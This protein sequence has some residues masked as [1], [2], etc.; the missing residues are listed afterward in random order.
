MIRY[1]LGE[2]TEEDQLRLEEQFLANEE[3]YQ[4]LLALEDELRYEYAQ[5][6]LPARQREQFERRFL[7]TA[8]DRQ[9]VALAQEILAGVNKAFKETSAAVVPAGRRRSTWWEGLASFFAMSRSGRRFAFAAAT[10]LVLLGASWLFFRSLQLQNRIAELEAERKSAQQHAIQELA[11]QRVQQEQ[12]RREVEQQR[13]RNVELTR[14]LAKAKPQTSANF[15]SFILA[16]GL[17][18]D[19]EGPRQLVI[20]ANAGFVRLQLAVKGQSSYQTYRAELQT[21]EGQQIWGKE[22]HQTTLIIP[23]RLLTLGDYVIELKG[24]D[25][26]G[27]SDEIGEYYFRVVAR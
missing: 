2:A 18:R 16:P 17:A 11:G 23:P 22:T 25:A 7:A 27:G 10:F 15:L 13:S 3:S 26:H 6:S 8:E 9:K 1:L 12:L 24:I 4:Q 20:P 14:E 19:T 5:G 21:V